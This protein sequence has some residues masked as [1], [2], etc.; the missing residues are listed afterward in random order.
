MM[1]KCGHC[2]G[3]SW[4]ISEEEPQ[5]AKFKMWFIRCSMCKVPIGVADYTHVPSDVARVE[6]SVKKLGNSVTS[7]LQVIDENVR[8]LFQK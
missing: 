6:E 8:R 4:E 3:F 5:Y 1:S 2:G 7:M